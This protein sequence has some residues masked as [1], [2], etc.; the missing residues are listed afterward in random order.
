MSRIQVT[1]SSTHEPNNNYIQLII[2]FDSES[3]STWT[4]S[5]RI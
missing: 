5:S 1:F 2:Q 3:S 4:C